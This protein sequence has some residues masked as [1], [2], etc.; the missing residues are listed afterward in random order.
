M[1]KPFPGSYTAADD[2]A[3]RAACEATI[4]LMLQGKEVNKENVLAWVSTSAAP[5]PSR[6]IQGRA[7]YFAE[8]MIDGPFRP[9]GSKE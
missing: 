8:R 5:I 9:D 2:F 6:E 4:G 7:V 1:D 3:F